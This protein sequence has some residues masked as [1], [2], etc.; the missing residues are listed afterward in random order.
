MKPIM[1]LKRILTICSLLAL[2]LVSSK[3]KAQDS[4]SSENSSIFAKYL[5]NS[6]L[7]KDVLTLFADESSWTNDNRDEFYYLKG[8]ALYNLKQLDGSANYLLKV[9]KESPYYPKS[10]FF[11][12]Y[13]LAHLGKAGKAFT[14]LDTIAFSDELL[15]ET[16]IFEK[17][18]IALLNRDTSLFNQLAQTFTFSNFNLEEQ[19]KIL[20]DINQ[21]IREFKPKSPFVAGLLSAIVPGLGKVYAGKLGGGV[22]AFLTVSV[23]G[24][25]TFE[26]IRKDGLDSPGAIIS[27]SL[28]AATYS[29]NIYGSVYSVK[30]YRDEFWQAMDYRILFNIHIP[31]RRI[32]N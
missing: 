11:G 9:S 24:A 6:G 27:G 7:F 18:G 1:V 17:A 30:A 32:F 10:I 12:A 25:I 4:I 23:L 31:L 5:I 20:L 21:Q 19:Q 13:N 3:G 26:N 16:L 29:A 22:S 14:T 15:A 8:W 2:F 28:L